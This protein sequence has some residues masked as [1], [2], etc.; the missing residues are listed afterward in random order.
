MYILCL[1]HAKY[2]KK[3]IMLLAFLYE[4]PSHL[5]PRGLTKQ[6]GVCGGGQSNSSILCYIP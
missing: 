3:K 1:S 6:R 5:P 4:N 2:V